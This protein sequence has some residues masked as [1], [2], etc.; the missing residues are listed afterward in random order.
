MLR[1]GRIVRF[2]CHTGHAFSA[3]TLLD[4]T[5]ESIEA[6]LWDAVRAADETVML[7][8]Q[9][10][11]EFAKAGNTSAAEKCFDKARD[12]HERLA[13]IREAAMENEEL[14]VEKLRERAV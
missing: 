4:A 8:N 11:E 9:L 5:T 7:L 1:E 10:G 13:P 3:D 2:R 14:G 6:R 12:A